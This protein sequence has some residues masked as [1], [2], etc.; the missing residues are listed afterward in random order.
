MAAYRQQFL[1]NYHVLDNERNEADRLHDGEVNERQKAKKEFATK[2]VHEVESFR[3]VATH[4]LGS[5]PRAGITRPS[6][7]QSLAWQQIL[8][9][10]PTLV[11]DQTGSGKTLACL[12]PKRKHL[13][14]PIFGF[15]TNRSIGRQQIRLALLAKFVHRYL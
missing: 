10:K 4:C 8:S 15:G 14:L 3:D 1:W 13:V 5:A 7:I 11:T 12:L 6:R 2:F 9:G